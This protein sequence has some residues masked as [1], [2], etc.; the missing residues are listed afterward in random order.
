M[1]LLLIFRTLVF[2]NW[3][4]ESARWNE[5]ARMATTQNHNSTEFQLLPSSSKGN[6]IENECDDSI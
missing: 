1:V 3:L 4:K 6:S 5:S 2:R